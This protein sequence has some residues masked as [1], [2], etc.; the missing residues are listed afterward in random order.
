MNESPLRSVS[1]AS[2]RANGSLGQAIQ[3]ILSG[4]NAHRI[5][6]GLAIGMW[7]LQV[8]EF[9]SSRLDDAYITFRYGQNLAEGHGLV[10]NPGQAV[11]GSTAPGYA[12][13]S[14]LVYRVVGQGLLPSVMA[15]I[16]CL[17]WIFQAG[18]LFVLLEDVV[19]PLGSLAIAASIALDGTGS[20]TWVALE[21]NVAVALNLWALVLALRKRW[22]GAAATSAVAGLVRPDAFVLALLLAGLG[23]RERGKRIWKPA[24]LFVAIVAPWL[25][26]SWCTYGSPIPQSAVSK[27]HQAKLGPYAVHIFQYSAE[28]LLSLQHP[29]WLWG[30]VGWGLCLIGAAKLIRRR[31]TMGILVAYGALEFLAYLYLRPFITQ[32][33]HLYPGVVV[34]AVCAWT[35]LIQVIALIPRPWIKAVPISACAFLLA[36]DGMRFSAV[37]RSHDTDYWFG[38]R[39]E[40]YRAVSEFL[41]KHAAPTDKIAAVEVGTLGYYTQMPMYDLGGLITKHPVLARDGPVPYRWLVV[42]RLYWSVAPKGLKPVTAISRYGFSV[43]VFD[44]DQ[45]VR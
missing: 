4:P 30:P 31:R 32:D 33:W 25:I 38:A 28:R 14:A 22:M 19:G 13:L 2:R 34:F 8:V 5:L 42:D 23:L 40:T 12:L 27:F 35:G 44:L 45:L 41:L 18:A 39:D 37:A 43:R 9:H 3:S 17:G 26:W 1:A 10:F 7:V 36:A 16:G 24:L 20:A 15:S 29:S 6:F 21:T 11:M